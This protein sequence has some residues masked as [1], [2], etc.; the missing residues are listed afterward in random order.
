[1]NIGYTHLPQ[2]TGPEHSTFRF[3]DNLPE[4]SSLLP[5]E[6]VNFIEYENKVHSSE[7]VASF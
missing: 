7:V 5:Q 6:V 3:S 2:S 4:N 1:M